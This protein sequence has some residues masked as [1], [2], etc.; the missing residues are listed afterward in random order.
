MRA[1]A[2]GRLSLLPLV[3][4]GRLVLAHD[5]LVPGRKQQRFA[6]YAQGSRSA[7]AHGYEQSARRC[8][9]PG[10]QERH[11]VGLH[12]GERGQNARAGLEVLSRD[13]KRS[14]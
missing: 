1:C 11:A 13:L 8:C 6:A 9:L 12:T 3:R 10:M 2:G 4:T 5:V 7:R 14:R